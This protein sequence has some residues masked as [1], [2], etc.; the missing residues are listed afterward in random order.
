MHSYTCSA[1]RLAFVLAL[2]LCAAPWAAAQTTYTVCPSGPPV[3][4]GDSIQDAVNFAMDGDVV[5]VSDGTYTENVVVDSKDITIR[6]QNGR[7]TTTIQGISGAGALGTLVVQGTTAGFTLEGFTVVGIDNGSPGLEN[8]AVYVR[9]SHTDLM[10]LANDVQADGDAGFLAEF[11]A[12]LADPVLDGNLFT[13][14]TFVGPNPAGAGFSQQFTLPNVP[15]QL[16][17][18]GNGGGTTGANVTGLVF[19]DNEVIGTAGGTNTDGDE[20]GNTLATLDAEN[21]TITGNL[22]AGTTTRFA[23]QLR[24]RRPGA[25]ITG[26]TF[27]SDGLGAITSHIF[28]QNN[29]TPLPGIAASNA[30]DKGAYAEH[31]IAV[32][33]SISPAVAGAPSGD[34]VHVFESDYREQVVVDGKALTL[35]GE[36]RAGVV[37]QAPDDVPVCFTTSAANKPVVCAINGADLEIETLTVDGRG[38]GNANVRF[39]G[40]AFRN[41]GGAVQDVAITGVRDSPL[42]GVQ[43]GIGLYAFN[44]DGVDRTIEVFDNEIVDFQKN[45]MALNAGT[46]APLTLDVQR[47]TVTGAGPIPTTAQ[48][49]IQ[50]FGDAI[51]GVVDDNDV[52]GIAYTG[53]GFVATSILNFNSA[54]DAGSNDID[55]AQTGMYW[56]DGKGTLAGND[57]DVIEAG[58]FSFGIVATDPP[59]AVPSPF[60]PQDVAARGG[61]A[62][63]IAVVVT[64][65]TVTF[66]TGS[67]ANSFGIEADAG[68]GVDNLDLTITE[69]DVTG[70]GVGV[71]IFECQTGC[72]PTTFSSLLV[73][74]NNLDGN[75]IAIRSNWSQT[76]DAPA[77][78]Y[79]DTDPSD[80]VVGDVDFSPWLEFPVDTDPQTFY[81]D[82]FI[83]EAVDYADSG[84][85]ILALAGT[86]VEQVIVDGL[87]L[88]ITGAGVSQTTVVAP[89][90]AANLAACTTT[91]G[92]NKP[93][94]CA[95]NGADLVIEELTVDGDGRAGNA[96]FYGIALYESS[97]VVR[98]TVVER[99]RATPLTG[100]QT[101]VGILAASLDAAGPFTVE[102]RNNTVRDFGKNGVTV[103]GANLTVV[104][105]SN[106]VVGSGGVDE[107]AQNGIQVSRGTLG[108]VT[109]NDVSALSF[110]PVDESRDFF[111]AG[112]IL[113]FNA[114]SVTVEG[115]TISACEGCLLAADSPSLI[116][117]NTITTSTAASDDDDYTGVFAYSFV[118]TSAARGVAGGVTRATGLV[119][120]GDA[121]GGT[122]EQQHLASPFLDGPTVAANGRA[123]TI[124]YDI[125]GNAIT[126]GDDNRG[127]GLLGY[128]Y[129]DG[130][131]SM[132]DLRV[133]DND[134]GGFDTGV[135]LCEGDSGLVQSPVDLDGG[136][137]LDGNDVALY[138][139]LAA[140]V[141]AEN[142]FWGVFTAAEIQDL[143]VNDGTGEVDFTPFVVEGVDLTATADATTVEP[144]GSVEFSYTVTNTTSNDAT[145]DLY[146]VAERDG[147][148]VR[149]GKIVGGTLP[150]G[151]SVSGTYTQNVPAGAPEDDYDYFLRIGDFANRTV[152]D[153]EAFVITVESG[154]SASANAL[155]GAT[156]LA[157][158]WTTEDATW[159]LGPLVTGGAAQDVAEEDAVEEDAPA[160]AAARADRPA[161][162][163]L[164]AAPNPAAHRTVF[165]LALPADGPVRVTVYDVQGRAVAVATDR[166]MEAGHHALP[167]DVAGLASGVYLVRAEAN[168]NV[169][170]RRITVVR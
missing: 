163:A 109:G 26:N 50:T 52:S 84:D 100:N 155:A 17:T 58:D 164:T 43:H 6:S 142:N 73:A 114:P 8:A 124:A 20:Q 47:N 134:I 149:R 148:V 48:N 71:E 169:V 123:G 51:T 150:A 69:N 135:Y 90:D 61:A 157:D 119:L 10:V 76:V 86:F 140:D 78:Y 1:R 38:V 138:T 79:G 49:G 111:D 143:I 101:T 81:T 16:V 3:C 36:S 55:G 110:D 146:F 24:I 45:G 83:Q 132:L 9:G 25:T 108:A 23:S 63:T 54:I 28:I 59:R 126:G 85:T 40:I 89:D 57:V 141:D 117:N 35:R 64:G 67:N 93:V 82:Q 19:T 87:A 129:Q 68:F 156:A 31:G 2:V 130:T 66:T 77:N 53:A 144:G 95:R 11:G 72:Q 98:N 18:L 161:V 133:E 145:L 13:G 131:S 127:V 22:F 12:T 107:L 121:G 15:R 102:L 165:H 153:E 14:Q 44:D 62:D 30:F 21:A 91:S 7:S 113:L 116:Q 5:L 74:Q 88:T 34:T 167:L 46:G 103:D 136:N 4:G 166:A 152:A 115:N 41:A 70:F 170:T 104:V 105:D 162:L 120:D 118:G 159:T 147:N 158:G 128:A 122:P 65:N 92:P 97:G 29:G 112:G 32:T 94:V 60:D 75:D 154:S 33:V 37:I 27:E 99:V 151:Q 56:F 168:G 106:T 125:L 96:R 39:H 137:E 160:E 80:D 42:S 139:C